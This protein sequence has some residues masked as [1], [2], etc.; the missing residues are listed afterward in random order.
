[1]KKY[2]KYLRMAGYAALLLAGAAGCSDDEPITGPVIVEEPSELTVQPTEDVILTRIDA[3]AAMMGTQ[4]DDVTERIL[5]RAGALMQVGRNVY[6]I[7]AETSVLF[8]DAPTLAYFMDDVAAH[9]DELYYLRGRYMDGMTICLHEPDDIHAFCFM[10]MMDV[11]DLN[12]D[13]NAPG[14]DQKVVTELRKRAAARRAASRSS[15]TDGFGDG[16]PTFDL[17]ALRRGTNGFYV[18]DLHK[19]EPQ[20]VKILSTGYSLDNP[21][22]ELTQETTEEY[23]QKEPT[24]YQYGC[25]AESFVKWFNQ[26]YNTE[27]SRG[28]KALAAGEDPGIDMPELADISRLVN[29]IPVHIRM[30][31]S[32]MYNF[33]TDEDYYHIYVEMQIEGDKAWRGV[34]RSEHENVQRGF[35]IHSVIPQVRWPY[36][37]FP[38]RDEWNVQPSSTN[39]PITTETVNGWNIGA[40]VGWDDDVTGKLTGGYTYTQKVTK[41]ESDVTVY[42]SQ[43]ISDGNYSNWIRWNYAFGDQ[44]SISKH[45]YFWYNNYTVHVPSS[46]STCV[47]NKSQYMSWNWLVK[48]TSARGDEPFVVPFE[49]KEFNLKWVQN[50]RENGMVNI[51]IWNNIANYWVEPVMLTLPTPPRAKEQFTFDVEDI[52][53]ATDY[54]TLCDILKQNVD[55]N[56]L[57][58]KLNKLD[59]NDNPVFRTGTTKVHLYHTLGKEFYTLAKAVLNGPKTM[60]CKYTYRF[61][62]RDSEGHLVP[63]YDLVNGKWTNMGT[64]LEVGPNGSNIIHDSDNVYGQ[65]GYVFQFNTGS[66]VLSF[67]VTKEG[68]ECELIEVSADY[69]GKLVIPSSVNGFQVTSVASGLFDD[70]GHTKLTSVTFPGSVKNV[71]RSQF[72]HLPASLEEVILSEGVET[73][74]ARFFLYDPPKRLYLPSTLKDYGLLAGNGKTLQELHVKSATPPWYSGPSSPIPGA[75]LEYRELG[76]FDTTVLYYPSSAEAA[77]S[78]HPVFGLYKNRKKE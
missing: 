17:W 60:G 69:A 39:P 77:Y 43:H 1:M 21:D 6:Y 12:E 38:V 70:K 18:P 75:N 16:D 64:Y 5:A 74:D 71:G 78:S 68:S 26:R 57:V 63:M 13:D 3:P 4:F 46:S 34:L 20:V 7:P 66:G 62:L 8:I 22:E 42:N 41:V 45:Y 67:K 27:S 31:A 19:T 51:I 59:E 14:A 76:N 58:T 2:T 35:S 48:N 40:E 53:D 47:S 15:L 61:R 50:Q 28:I 23:I 72:G 29:G 37:E 54:K 55:Y 24:P 30:N 49:F 11:L 56:S 9:I 10:L 33:N 25:I 65:V 52:P 73:M 32:S 44:L 36:D